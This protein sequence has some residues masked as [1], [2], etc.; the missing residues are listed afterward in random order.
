MA[1]FHSITASVIAFAS[2]LFVF[3]CDWISQPRAV[4]S[5]AT[6]IE[7]IVSPKGVKFMFPIFN[8]L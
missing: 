4:I 8:V 2:S 6:I 5:D 1:T 3:I 7:A